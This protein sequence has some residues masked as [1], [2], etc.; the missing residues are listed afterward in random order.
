MV[1]Y[2]A[3]AVNPDTKRLFNN[4]KTWIT[5]LAKAFPYQQLLCGLLQING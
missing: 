4:K 5:I 2:E 1:E 3:M